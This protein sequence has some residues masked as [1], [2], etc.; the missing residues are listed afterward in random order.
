MIHRILCAISMLGGA[1]LPAVAVEFQALRQV[2]LAGAGAGDRILAI[3]IDSDAHFD[4]VVNPSRSDQA[5]FQDGVNVLLGDGQGGFPDG[6]AVRAGVSLSGLASGDFNGDG[7]SDIAVTER[8]RIKDA[9]YQPCA[10]LTPGVPVFLGNGN[11]SFTFKSCLQA[12]DVPAAA[13]AGDFNEDGRVDLVIVN[14]PTAAGGATTQD[15]Y[16][17]AGQ[18]GGNFAAGTVIFQLRGNDVAAADFNRDNHLD[19]AI[20]NASSTYIFPG[21]GNGTFGPQGPALT[22]PAARIAAG[23]LNG[24]GAPDIAAVGSSLA[25]STDDV[26]WT[27][28]NNGSGTL[29]AAG[30]VAVG[31][32]PV[33]VTIADLNLDGRGDVITANQSG[34]NISVLI[35][36]AAGFAPRADFPAGTEPTGVTAADLD[37]DGFPDL[38]IANN[39][40]GQD[41]SVALLIQAAPAALPLT[42]AFAQAAVGGG[43]STD[44]ILVNTGGTPASGTMTVLDQQGGAISSVPLSIPPGGLA[45]STLTSNSGVT[46]SG[47]VRVE[48]AGGQISGVATFQ[49]VEAGL[50][51]TVAGVLMSQPTDAATIPVDNDAAAGRYTGYAI[52]NPG[53]QPITIRFTTVNENGTV[54]D[55]TLTKQ[56]GPNEQ[57]ARFLHEDLVS[58]ATFRGS[59]VLTGVGGTRFV[60]VALL[61]KNGLLSAIPALSSKAPHIP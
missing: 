27:A 52:A 15:V 51:K 50:L 8:V 39:N 48:A 13:A 2:A 26:V 33:G 38:A 28:V 30:S 5:I 6:G 40:R 54:R 59:M 22:G 29:T 11:G 49:R 58:H 37:G 20:G 31:S 16:L 17:F 32:H 35:S 53:T 10:T 14:A 55:T 1:V 4:L 57:L 24:D 47:W 21:L 3:R 45:S 42:G 18:G 56:L 7:V 12:G 43:Y 36:Q 61:D 9:A 44:F 34:N 23:D 60:A 46:Q 25:S 19:L 41:G